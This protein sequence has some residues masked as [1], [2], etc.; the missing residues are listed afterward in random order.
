MKIMNPD[1]KQIDVVPLNILLRDLVGMQIELSELDRIP[2]AVE[3]MLS[4]SNYYHEEIERL[5]HE[6]IYHLGSSAKVAADYLIH[7]LQK[8][9]SSKGE[10]KKE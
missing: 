7:Q 3:K 9:L 10:T 6:H 5:A 8:K 2:E 1:Y 4:S